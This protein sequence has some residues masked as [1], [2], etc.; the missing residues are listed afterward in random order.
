METG[1]L[2]MSLLTELGM[3]GAGFSYKHVAPNCAAAF[4]L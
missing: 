4:L 2:F 1:G 3:L